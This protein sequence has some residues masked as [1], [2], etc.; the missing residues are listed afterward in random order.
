MTSDPLQLLIMML[1]MV[2]F[3]F[4][5]WI[6]GRI[7]QLAAADQ[8]E[9]IPNILKVWV[10]TKYVESIRR[11]E[12]KPVKNYKFN[13]YIAIFSLPFPCIMICSASSESLTPRLIMV[14]ASTIL[15]FMGV[16]LLE[17]VLRPRSK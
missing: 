16:A 9:R 14:L 8:D 2:A 15:F 3:P 4:I 17:W 10:N 12:I 7:T 1:T 5:I 13:L 11:G 6:P